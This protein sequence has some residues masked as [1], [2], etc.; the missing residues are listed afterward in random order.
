M[1]FLLKPSAFALSLL[2]L[3]TASVAPT[4]L[5]ESAPPRILDLSKP[6]P[7]RSENEN[8]DVAWFKEILTKQRSIRRFLVIEDGE[9]VLDYQRNTVENDDVYGIWS[10][11]KAFTGM[12]IGSVMASDEYDL[13]IDDTLGDIF[14]GEKDWTA[15]DDPEELASK[16]NVTIYE[17]LTMTS[18]L[19]GFDANLLSAIS[20]NPSDGEPFDLANGAG[21]NLRRS[22]VYHDWNATEKGQYNYLPI[23]NILSYVIVAVTGMTPR[24]YA[25]ANIFPSIGIDNN[26]IDW[27]KNAQV[28]ANEKGNHNY[29]S[30]SNILS[31]VILAV[32]GM[33]PREYTSVDVFPSLGIDNNKI[34]WRKNFQGVEASLSSLF[35]TARDM[36]KVAQ[37]YLQK[38]KAA[39]NKQ[40][41]PEE[42]IKETLSHHALWEDWPYGY[43]W[44]YQEFNVN[45]FPNQIGE[46]MWC[47]IGGMGQGYC[48]NYESKRVVAYQRSNTVWDFSNKE[49]LDAMVAAAFSADFTFN[50]TAD[51]TVEEFVESGASSRSALWWILAPILGLSVLGSWK[52]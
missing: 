15:I 8:T 12:L 17:L 43:F 35:M 18:G 11:T 33:T 44:A 38:G 23:S 24:E 16:Q 4:T 28:N 46:G 27:R 2:S 51:P 30:I 9:I 3:T 21:I 22:L 14:T 45:I 36:A 39:P 5:A 25:A 34:D 41:L 42:F 48:F 32:T 40:L 13:S 6:F 26:K 47:A 20:R 10:A 52:V 29:L 1:T 7:V 31:Y 50:E 37:L 19:T 49:M